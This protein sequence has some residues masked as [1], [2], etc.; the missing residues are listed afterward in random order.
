VTLH[1][2][3]QDG[4]SLLLWKNFKIVS[5]IHL[6]LSSR[7]KPR[8]YFDGNRILVFGEDHIGSIILVYQVLGPEFQG[9]SEQTSTSG[10]ASG[11][12][13]HLCEPPA[14]RFANRI[15]HVA[16]GGIEGLDSMHMTCND[17]F[18][19]ANTRTGNHLGSSPCP[20]GLLLI[21]LH[22]D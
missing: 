14:V 5:L 18:V 20:E 9:L 4:S 11:G 6:R 17:R 22:D 8:I 7:R 15:R 1:H 16:L 19:L 12:V 21:D 10:E 13:Y 2:V 3:P